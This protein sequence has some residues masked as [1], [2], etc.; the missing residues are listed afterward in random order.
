[1]AGTRLVMRSL[2]AVDKTSL[3]TRILM[4]FVAGRNGWTLV[5]THCCAKVRLVLML[6]IWSLGTVMVISIPVLAKACRISGLASKSLTRLIVVDCE[7][8]FAT[9]AG[10]GR[11]FATVP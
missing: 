2:L 8:N 11:L 7:R 3:P 10:G 6:G 9:L 5:L 1:M 4:M